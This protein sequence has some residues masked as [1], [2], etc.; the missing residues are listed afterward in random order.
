MKTLAFVIVL[1]VAAPASAAWRRVDS[2]NF[3]VVGD[4]NSTMACT[5][6]GAKLG[7][8]VA[9]LEAGLRSRDRGMP[10]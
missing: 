4:V 5:L 6:V 2:P 10:E 1:A 9:H 8:K 7:I 3:I